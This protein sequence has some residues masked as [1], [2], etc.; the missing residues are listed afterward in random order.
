MLSHELLLIAED[1]PDDALLLRRALARAGIKARL[2]FVADGEEMLFYLQGDGAYSDRN[3]H[4]LPSAI[5]MDLKMPRKTGLE[6]LAWLS[7]HPEVAV[8]PTV[9]L[10][11]SNMPDDVRQAYRL[12]ANTYFV[13]PTSF[14]E[15]VA[16]MEN[17][18][19]YWVSAAR[20]P[21]GACD[22]TTEH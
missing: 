7:S 4:P 21:S 1:N 13:K 6:V 20:L 2:K 11:S 14:D 3:I 9:I 19:K 8:V 16:T 5:I 10:S 12:G 18:R 22:T 15:L 17:L